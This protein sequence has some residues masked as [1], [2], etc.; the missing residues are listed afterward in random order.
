MSLNT[1]RSAIEGRIATEFAASPAIQVSYG[2]VPFTPPN[3]GSFIQVFVGFGEQGYITLMSPGVGTNRVNGAIT[4][5]IFTPRGA[6]AGANMTIAQRFI[7][8]FSRQYVSNIRFDAAIGPAT[9]EASVNET[10][11][12]AQTALAASFYQ[13]QITIAFEAFE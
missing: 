1:V 2:N 9:I 7:D 11:I 4:A 5:N 3:N 8:L 12:S 10:G 6:G 13:S